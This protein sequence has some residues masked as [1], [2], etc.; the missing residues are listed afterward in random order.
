MNIAVTF[1]DTADTNIPDGA[2]LIFE[3][4]ADWDV[5]T[6]SDIEDGAFTGIA[7]LRLEA[8]GSRVGGPLW[9]FPETVT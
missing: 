1:T 9:K 3:D 4:V 7:H 5:S 6:P 8:S 2:V